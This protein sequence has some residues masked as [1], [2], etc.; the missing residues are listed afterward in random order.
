MQC[1]AT[2][3]Q[4]AQPT[5][6]FNYWH[7]KSSILKSKLWWHWQTCASSAHIHTNRSEQ[8]QSLVICTHY[9]S[10]TRLI[11]RNS[12]RWTKKTLT[13]KLIVHVQWN[14]GEIERRKEA[15]TNSW[16]SQPPRP[17]SALAQPA[18]PV[19]EVHD[20]LRPRSLSHPRLTS[21]P[22][23]PTCHP[24]HRA[25]PLLFPLPRQSAHVGGIRGWT[26]HPWPSAP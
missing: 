4:Q 7:T 22:R 20:R 17:S 9:I 25:L 24:L 14:R 13:D 15:S 16:P 26:S 18:T 10:K 5:S 19:S 11:T 6:I 12:K 8:Q 3:A 1:N 2:D 23:W 21:G